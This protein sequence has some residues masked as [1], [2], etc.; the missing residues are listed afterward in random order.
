MKAYCAITAAA[1]VAAGAD[2]R[3]T[4]PAPR[5]APVRLEPIAGTSLK[6][7]F[8]TSKA[9]ERL[10][11]ET[12]KVVE[13]PII[14]KQM[15]SGLVA[16]SVAPPPTTRRTFSA[17]TV[18]PRLA[19]AARSA[20]A[21]AVGAGSGSF[22]I[23]GVAAA[24]AAPP[25]PPAEAP[26]A[27]PIRGEASVLVALSESEWEK[28]AKDKAARIFPLSA[29][30][31][32]ARELIAFPSGTPPVEDMKR[33]MLTV[34]Y[35]V[36]DPNHGLTVNKRVRVELEQAGNEEK[37]RVV[38]YGAVYYD[39]SGATWAYVRTEPLVFERRRIVVDR[40]DGDLAALSDGPPIGTDVVVVGAPLLYGAEIFGK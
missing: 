34:S 37:R 3:K 32:S 15:V 22:A 36:R 9:A 33:A 31:T 38:P 23:T 10:G 20:P 6:R 35:V 11:I 30:D 17:F 19:A 13:Q 1:V 27:A 5:S 24:S 18:D 25:A 14:R 2:P 16:P 39:A 21:A 4:E 26:Q 29:G 40:V 12:S 8:L 7:V 28:L